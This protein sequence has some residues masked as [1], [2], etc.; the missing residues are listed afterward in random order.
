MKALRHE[1]PAPSVL[2]ERLQEQ[3]GLDE[4]PRRRSSSPA[5]TASTSARRCSCARSSRSPPAARSA[6][7]PPGQL[8]PA[9]PR[10]SHHLDEVP[11]GAIVSAVK[12]DH[13]AAGRL[14]TAD[15]L[16][17]RPGLAP[18]AAARSCTAS[19]PPTAE[20]DSVKL[21]GA[22]ASLAEGDG[23]L[24]AS[25]RTRRPAARWSAPRGRC[26]CGCC[27]SG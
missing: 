10:D 19:S 21:S 27:A 13:L 12:A 23:A 4:P 25:A 9:D 17:R 2:R 6:A 8:T 5:P 18:A 22:L 7:A 1:A 11:E 26:T 16:L 20:R 15:E 24:D 3:A 14:A